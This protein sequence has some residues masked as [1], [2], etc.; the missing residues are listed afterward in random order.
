M[1]R[2]LLQ[3]II[4]VFGFQTDF[5]GEEL[6]FWFRG[7]VFGQALVHT[8]KT[9][10]W[11]DCQNEPFSFP[12]V[13]LFILWII[14]SKQTTKQYNLFTGC[15]CSS[16]S[17]QMVHA[18]CNPLYGNYY[19]LF[20]LKLVEDKNRR[21]KFCQSLKTFVRYFHV[22]QNCGFGNVAEYKKY[23]SGMWQQL[24][25]LPHNVCSILVQLYHVYYPSVNTR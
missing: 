1:Y 16:E 6:H 15:S 2:S 17:S 22:Q 23:L 14:P 4:V 10:H 7:S 19:W 3:S 11:A 5:D 8:G 21:A 12:H 18:H 24:S 20:F 9:P 13:K 25:L